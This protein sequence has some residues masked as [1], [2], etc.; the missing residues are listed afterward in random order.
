MC[1]SCLLIIK[2]L[3][4]VDI[5]RHQICVQ[6]LFDVYEGLRIFTH[7]TSPN[8]C[9]EFIQA[10]WMKIEQKLNVWRFLYE[11]IFF[12]TNRFL[13]FQ[14]NELPYLIYSFFYSNQMIF[15]IWSTI[16]SFQP[17]EFPN[18]SDLLFI[19]S[20]KLIWTSD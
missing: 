13:L 8:L 4:S 19:I 7:M 2:D 15:L 1:K 12:C 3:E 11:E 14:P 20:I 5:W 10:N 6:K 16:L 9:L 18:K 17:N